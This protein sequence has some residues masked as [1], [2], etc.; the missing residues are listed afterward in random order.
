MS[1]AQHARERSYTD[2]LVDAINLLNVDPLTI[3]TS[4]LKRAYR[5]AAI[6]YHPDMNNGE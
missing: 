5:D 2:K 1:T 6:N 4:S 3:N